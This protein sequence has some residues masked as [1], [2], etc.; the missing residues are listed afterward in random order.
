MV[1][2]DRKKK[3]MQTRE[4]LRKYTSLRLIC[5]TSTELLHIHLCV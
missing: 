3:Q 4:I 5:T 1:S 2:L